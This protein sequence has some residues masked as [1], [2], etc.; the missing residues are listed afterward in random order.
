MEI[1]VL[2]DPEAVFRECARGIVKRVASKPEAVL[3]LATGQTML[4]VYGELVRAYR[5]GEV[6]FSRVTTFN[7][8]EYLGLPP[9]DP[10]T[11]RSYMQEN[12]FSMVDIPEKNIHIPDSQPEDVGAECERYEI[13][14][15]ERGGI[16][17]Q[18]LGLGRDGHIGFNEPSSSLRARTRVKTLT[19]ETLHDNFDRKPGPRFAITMGIGT[20]LE[21]HAIIL[22]AIGPHKAEPLSL[23]VE[24]PL[25]ASCP[26]SALQLHPLVK[27]ICDGEAAARLKRRDY[28]EW[29]WR[30]KHEVGELTRYREK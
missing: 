27:I 1:I 11:F 3:G 23:A 21:A 24:G 22:A 12:F 28:Y 29:V 15:R 30:H 7:L 19:E 17:V 26:A 25:S 6:C 2:S 13:L 4:G 10:R 14:I 18:L 5:E 16:D 20:I 9:H 8:D